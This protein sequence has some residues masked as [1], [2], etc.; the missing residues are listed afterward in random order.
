MCTDIDYYS[1]ATL[2]SGSAALKS[3]LHDIISPHTVVSYDGAWAAL[4]DLDV[5]EDDHTR[6]RLIYSSHTHHG[7]DDQGVSSGWNREHSWPKSY[8]IGYSGPDY[9]DLHAL[10]AADWNVNSARS[11]LY[12]DNCFVDCTS[13]AHAEASTD[14]AKDSVR[15]MPP[16]SVRG[17]LARAAFYMAVRYDGTEANTED[18]E[19]ADVPDK[20]TFTL[21]VLS[22][23]LQWHTDDPVSG[24]ERKRNERICTYQYNRNPFVDH[25]EFVSCVFGGDCTVSPSPPPLPPRPPPPPAPPPAP[26]SPPPPPLLHAGDC[27]VIFMQSDSPDAAAVLLLATL[28]SGVPLLLTDN[29]VYG[30][31]TLRDTEGVRSYTPSADVPA[32][33]VLTLADHFTESVSGS[34]SLSSAGDQLSVF[35]GSVSSPTFLCAL[36]TYVVFSQGPHH[37]E[38]PSICYPANVP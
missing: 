1:G 15:F 37:N 38:L 34:I 29:G 22:T 20:A 33:T 25:P 23:L 31:G 7:V 24:R 16:A 9:S 8:G 3:A 12:F 17:D 36:S 14:T 32:G 26:P 21:G 30:D 11:N 35:T 19:L 10:F 6:V 5:A 13:P 27:A 28:P 18:L 4:R 2:A